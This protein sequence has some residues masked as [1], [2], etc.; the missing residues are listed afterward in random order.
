MNERVAWQLSCGPMKKGR[1]QSH[2]G[3]RPH[4]PDR[5]LPYRHSENRNLFHKTYT[6]KAGGPQ[7]IAVDVPGQDE[8]EGERSSAKIS[9]EGK[10]QHAGLLLATTAVYVIYRGIR[11][12]YRSI[13]ERRR[14]TS[15]LSG[16]TSPR[17]PSRREK[18]CLRL[19]GPT[20][21]HLRHE[22]TLF[23]CSM[24]L[25]AAALT[26]TYRGGFGSWGDIKYLL[27]TGVLVSRHVLLRW[28]CPNDTSTSAH[29]TVPGTVAKLLS[30]CCSAGQ[31]FDTPPS[32]VAMDQHELGGGEMTILIRAWFGRIKSTLGRPLCVVS[33]TFYVCVQQPILSKFFPAHNDGHL[34]NPQGDN[35]SQFTKSSGGGYHGSK[36]KGG[37]SGSGSGRRERLSFRDIDTNRSSSP[38]SSFLSSLRTYMRNADIKRKVEICR[39]KYI[40]PAQKCIFIGAFFVIAFTFFCFHSRDKAA[41]AAAGPR[42]GFPGGGGSFHANGRTGQDPRMKNTNQNRNSNSN[43]QDATSEFGGGLGGLFGAPP[44]VRHHSHGPLGKSA[45]TSYEILF[46]LGWLSTVVSLVI[47]GRGLLPV[48]DLAASTTSQKVLRM[49]S[50]HGG[51]GKHATKS[52][53]TDA[54]PWAEQYHSI[55]SQNRFKVHCRVIFLRIIENIFLCAIIPNTEFACIA[56]GHCDPNPYP[57]DLPGFMGVANT[58]YKPGGHPRTMFEDVAHDRV[59][60]IILGFTVAIVTAAILI[61]QVATLDRTCLAISG[62]L[63]Q[64]TSTKSDKGGRSG[65][66][67]KDRRND[68]DPFSS[69]DKQKASRGFYSKLMWRI[70]RGELGHPSTSAIVSYACLCLFG[71]LFFLLLVLIVYLSSGRDIS[72]VLFIIAAVWKATKS[73]VNVGN[74]DHIK[75]NRLATEITA[76][77]ESHKERLDYIMA[78]HEPMAEE[79]ASAITMQSS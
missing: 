13:S 51:G 7:F 34:A 21:L 27:L 61:S 9:E 76:P 20:T 69:L 62:Y 12:N 15:R 72:A 50:R 79:E 74:L 43:Q 55:N 2:D 25:A 22:Y 33:H 18:A 49:E 48:P 14:H 29:P 39:E 40:P 1:G 73:T 3:P 64:D 78:A 54:V 37:G 16:A 23:I 6:M 68:T 53:H 38:F 47:F 44:G 11:G 60:C 30:K 66:R 57:W 17:P 4:A 5:S 52:K 28:L 35:D 19:F 36:R 75:L 63:S 26:S 65:G 77:L 56:T 67:H 45:P 8:A 71:W 31:Y 24:L 41:V 58:R 59:M 10:V 42:A 46:H 70:F 32:S